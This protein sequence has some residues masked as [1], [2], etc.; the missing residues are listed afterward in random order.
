MSVKYYVNENWKCVVFN[1]DK[2]SYQ[3]LPQLH[4]STGCSLEKLCIFHHLTIHFPSENI[5]VQAAI[6]CYQQIK[7]DRVQSETN[8]SLFKNILIYLYHI[9]IDS[10]KDIKITFKSPIKSTNIILAARRRQQLMKNNH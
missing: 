3:H 10:I 1:Y 7:S 8:I 9:L 6:R 4:K 2:S 5:E